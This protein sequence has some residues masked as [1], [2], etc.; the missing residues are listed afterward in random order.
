MS[1]KCPD[2][3]REGLDVNNYDTDPNCAYCDTPRN[4]AARRDYKRRHALDD[5][6]THKEA[7]A[8]VSMQKVIDTPVFDQPHSPLDIDPDCRVRWRDVAPYILAG[9]A[10]VFSFCAGYVAGAIHWS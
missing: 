9:A 5:F 1:W 7:S 2:C 3:S 6:W 10:L 4:N 8:K